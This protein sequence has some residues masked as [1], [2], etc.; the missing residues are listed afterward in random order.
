[1]KP[2]RRWA[3]MLPW[4]QGHKALSGQGLSNCI[5]KS[6]GGRVYSTRDAARVAEALNQSVREVSEDV[7]CK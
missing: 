4:A 2:G 5:A 1:M 6:T 3:C 7:I